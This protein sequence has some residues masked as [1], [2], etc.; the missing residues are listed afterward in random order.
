MRADSASSS[1]PRAC[2]RAAGVEADGDPARRIPRLRD[3]DCP[4]AVARCCSRRA[5]CETRSSPSCRRTPQ[6]CR[7]HVAGRVDGDA[8]LRSARS[9]A[10]GRKWGRRRRERPAV[11]VHRDEDVARGRRAGGPLHRRVTVRGRSRPP[12]SRAGVGVRRVV[13]S[14]GVAEPGVG[15]PTV[16][17]DELV[18][19]ARCPR[20]PPSDPRRS[21]AWLPVAGLSRADRRRAPTTRGVLPRASRR[22][23]SGFPT[24]QPGPAHWVHTTSASPAGRSRRTASNASPGRPLEMSPGTSPRPAGACCATRI[25]LLPRRRSRPT[26]RCRTR[27]RRSQPTA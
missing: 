17:E 23:S 6:V 19:R 27:H 13:S 11:R 15:F 10:V 1:R 2:S 7:Q 9:A 24:P 21:G 12:G 8:A 16:A 3:R 25:T 4:G 5:G 20:R 14:F 26:P 18:R 22:G